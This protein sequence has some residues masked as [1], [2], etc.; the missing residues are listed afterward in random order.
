M[1]TLLKLRFE[2]HGFVVFRMSNQKVT[3][4]TKEADRLTRASRL[5]TA[6]LI[7][8][9]LIAER[10][11]MFNNCALHKSNYKMSFGYLVV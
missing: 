6:I 3:H 8:S 5:Q 7:S 10:N 9:G 11:V 2:E 4:E 1:V